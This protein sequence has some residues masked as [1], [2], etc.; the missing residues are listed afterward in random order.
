MKVKVRAIIPAPGGG[1]VIAH[2]RRLA[3][4]HLTLPGGR[5]ERG[6]DLSQAI[7]REVREETGLEVAPGPLLYVAEV[8]HSVTSQQLN[9]VFLCELH[10]GEVDL[11]CVVDE[12]TAG[13]GPPILDAVF[14]D[15]AAGWKDTPRYLGNIYRSRTG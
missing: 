2:E 8:V 13:I 1:V 5:P 7:V 6:E 9:V 4:D 12:P 10:G 15:M 3:R 11:E 14:A